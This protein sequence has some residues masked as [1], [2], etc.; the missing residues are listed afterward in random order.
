MMRLL[1]VIFLGLIQPA[2][3]ASAE[4]ALT[5]WMKGLEGEAPEPICSVARADDGTMTV[6]VQ[7]A[8]NSFPA[9]P[10]PIPDPA[11]ASAAFDAVLARIKDGMLVMNEMNPEVPWSGG[12]GV[13]L[14]LE[15][16]GKRSVSRVAGLDL[17]PELLAL[18]EPLGDGA[19]T[20]LA[21]R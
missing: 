14:W 12:A 7:N 19:C 1:V 15:A 18:F 2:T 20:R 13:E 8:M 6:R 5:L 11:S 17:L 9:R 3:A 4:V 21:K 10:E 16:D